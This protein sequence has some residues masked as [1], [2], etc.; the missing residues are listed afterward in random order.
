MPTTA[1]FAFSAANRAAVREHLEAHRDTNADG[2]D[3]GDDNAQRAGKRGGGVSV[4]DVAKEL[5][6]RW[7]LLSDD[8]RQGW[9]ETAAKEDGG[10]G[11]VKRQRTS[12]DDAQTKASPASG[13][14]IARLKKMLMR[15]AELKRVARDAMGAVSQATENFI[16]YVSTLAY[17]QAK[18]SKRKTVKFEDFAACIRRHQNLG[19]LRDHLP[20]IREAVVNS[21]VVTTSLAENEE[22]RRIREAERNAPASKKK[23][24]DGSAASVKTAAGARKQPAEMMTRTITSFF[25]AA[26]TANG[27]DTNG[28]EADAAMDDRER[29][30]LPGVADGDSEDAGVAPAGGEIDVAEARE[31]AIDDDH[32]DDGDDDD[33]EVEE[34]VDDDDD[35]DADIL[36][37]DEHDMDQQEEEEEEEEDN[38]AGDGEGEG[39]EVHC[40]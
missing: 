17:Q 6:K 22:R 40:L 20:A 7:R 23:K 2:A 29:D 37:E 8:E 14:P 27:K 5:G 3:V 1:Y 9:K 21:T 15:D 36:V 4:A 16:V 25:G 33:D 31:G 18:A 38:E 26:A 39:D 13:I 30:A 28:G 12:A 35:D 24:K 32:H 19:F 34:D 11:G 10:R